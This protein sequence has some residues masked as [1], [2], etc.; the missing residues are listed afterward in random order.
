MAET[1]FI[2]TLLQVSLGTECSPDTE[3]QQCAETFTQSTSTNLM[4]NNSSKRSER[5]QSLKGSEQQQPTIPPCFWCLLS[6][7]HRPSPRALKEERR[8]NLRTGGVGDCRWWITRFWNELGFLLEFVFTSEEKQP[9]RY[10]APVK[11]RWT[12]EGSGS[13]VEKITRDAEDGR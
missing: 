12:P 8:E 4:G 5:S 2:R 9:D 11:K 13:S 10:H 6:C 3:P 7:C 1:T